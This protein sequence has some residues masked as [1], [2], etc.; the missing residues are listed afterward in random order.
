MRVHSPLPLVR[1]ALPPMRLDERGSVFDLVRHSG[2]NQRRALPRA[3][4]GPAGPRPPRKDRILATRENS[5]PPFDLM[6]W[7]AWAGTLKRVGKEK[8]FAKNQEVSKEESAG[9]KFSIATA[10][11]PSI[12]RLWHRLRW[13]WLVVAA[14][15][16]RGRR[17]TSTARVSLSWPSS[18]DAESRDR[19][20]RQGGRAD[21]VGSPVQAARLPRAGRAGVAVAPQPGVQVLAVACWQ[22][23][24]W[25]RR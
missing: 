11:C 4:R 17:S 14:C 24:R 15:F 1:R 6:P 19:A 10:R 3:P 2:R 13:S 20:L 9:T 12:H 7:T 25:R 5:E 22:W 21:T 8:I 18:Q 16:A 23:R